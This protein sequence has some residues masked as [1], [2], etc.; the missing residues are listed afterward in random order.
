MRRGQPAFSEQENGLPITLILMV[1]IIF[2]ALGFAALSGRLNLSTSYVHNY[3]AQY[4]AET[5]LNRVSVKL[6]P[7][8]SITQPVG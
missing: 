5:G 3:N 8:R 7:P 1:C 6:R 2:V 4:I